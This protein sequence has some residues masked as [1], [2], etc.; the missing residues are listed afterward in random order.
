MLL[1][2]LVL[3]RLAGPENGNLLGGNLD[4]LLGV[5]GIASLPGSSFPDF[6]GSEAYQ[7]DLLSLCERTLDGSD[8]GVDRM[9]CHFLAHIRRLGKLIHEVGLGHS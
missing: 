9:S 1:C 6:E 5:L 8:K 7:L 4:D 3:Q 2:N